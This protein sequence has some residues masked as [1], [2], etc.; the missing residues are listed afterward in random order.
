MVRQKTSQAG[1][2]T[3]PFLSI[4][5]D[6]STPLSVESLSEIMANSFLSPGKCP[7]SVLLGGV[8][9]VDYAINDEPSEGEPLKGELI[10]TFSGEI[11]GEIEEDSVGLF[12]VSFQEAVLDETVGG[13]I[14]LVERG[15]VVPLASPHSLSSPPFLPK[16]RACLLV[17]VD[18]TLSSSSGGAICFNNDLIDRLRERKE[19]EDAEIVLFTSYLV[20]FNL[21]MNVAAGNTRW[22]VL[23]HLEERGVKV[24]K[25]I[26]T[27]SPYAERMGWEGE[28]GVQEEEG[29]ERE[30]KPKKGEKSSKKR[31]QKEEREKKKT[32]EGEGK[33]KEKEKEKEKKEN[34]KTNKSS[35]NTH[36]AFGRYY[37]DFI[38]KIEKEGSRLHSKSNLTEF[39]H[40][41]TQH[42]NVE[43]PF[44]S[45]RCPSTRD[46]VLALREEYR[47]FPSTYCHKSGKEEMFR[48]VL[49]EFG[50]E[51]G[52]K[53]GKEN[54]WF[55]IFDDKVEVLKVAARLWWAENAPLSW[56]H[57]I[58]RPKE[59]GMGVGESSG[60]KILEDKDKGEKEKRC[61]VQ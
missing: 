27:G 22:H 13:V 53:G 11:M 28:V 55:H 26:T 17:D 56:E 23:R 10:L 30:E 2:A 29:E 50:G 48:Y 9:S 4:P 21:R 31:D 61:P 25:V 54:V 52:E 60:S 34:A 6:D 33:K 20:Q 47:V 14:D 44:L 12:A 41:V 49:R 3:D 40:F 1:E 46:S 7:P 42:Q 57:I 15:Q 35:K 24:E 38:E 43:L 16:T 45:V 18:G 37:F 51:K 19:E 59:G 32:G 58:F 8:V 39:D 5:W 36:P